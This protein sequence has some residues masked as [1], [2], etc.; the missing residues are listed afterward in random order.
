ML[1]RR[2]IASWIFLGSVAACSASSGTPTTQGNQFADAGG[3]SGPGSGAGAAN[4]AGLPGAP[5]DPNSGGPNFGDIMERPPM[6]DECGAI[7]SK[8]EQITVDLFVMFDQSQSMLCGIPSGGDRWDAVKKALQDFVSA[9]EAAGINIGIQYFGLGGMVSSCNAADYQRP[10]VE[11]GPLPM[12]AQPIVNSLNAQ[13]PVSNTP[14]PAALDGAIR[15]AVDWKNTHTGHTVV[16]VL[17][18]DGQPNACGRVPDVVRIA[19]AGFT[20]NQILTYVIGIIS[21]GTVC[22]AGPNHANLDPLPP[23]RADLDSVARAGGTMAALMVD[24]TKNP[25]QEFVATMNAIRGRT[26]VPCQYGMPEAPMG[27]TLDPTHV[28]VELLPAGGTMPTTVFGVTKETCDPAKGGW[29]Y[30]NPAA[31][32]KINLCPA[33]CTFATTATGIQVNIAVGC[34]TK[35]PA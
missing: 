22:A 1:A 4:S 14:T 32:T 33:T 21:P 30:D 6:V 26:Q 25:G 12:N 8:G 10:D 27:K 5:L 24:V 31:P 13:S 35:G 23:N 2:P 15:H 9:P 28:N 7:T 18:T 19:G 17:V 20:N 16:V 34:K 11:I 3:A 29:F